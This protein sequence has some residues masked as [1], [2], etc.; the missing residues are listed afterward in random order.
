MY[1]KGSFTA[2]EKKIKDITFEIFKNFEKEKQETCYFNC[3]KTFL[4]T[5]LFFYLNRLQ[6]PIIFFSILAYP[7]PS[8]I[9]KHVLWSALYYR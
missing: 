9:N 2:K 3:S 8:F 7:V 4:T 6:T 5:S 1:I